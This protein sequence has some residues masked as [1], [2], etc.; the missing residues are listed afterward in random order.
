VGVGLLSLAWVKQEKNFYTAILAS[1][2]EFG[3]RHQLLVQP[4]LAL[5]FTTVLAL[6]RLMFALSESKRQ[7]GDPRIAFT[8][9]LAS[10]RNLFVL[11]PFLSARTLSHMGNGEPIQQTITAIL[12]LTSAFDDTAV[13]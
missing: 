7:S 12:V 5:R 6:T 2:R 1:S 4:L 3:S 11:K 10:T 8:A 13:N 9:I